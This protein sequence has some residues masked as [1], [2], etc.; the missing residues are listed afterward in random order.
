M[1]EAAPPTQ[2][3]ARTEAGVLEL[4]WSDGEVC[5]LPF[6]T[7]RGS[8]PCAACVDEFT[9][10]RLVGPEAVDPDV[11]PA[12][13]GFAGNYALKI[14]WSDGHETG[15]YTWS[16]LRELCETQGREDEG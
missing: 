8:C 12:D 9:G 4:H 2:I 5:R 11:R 16:Y 15:L 1:A 3:R 10:R 13:A 6:R 7:L 14:T